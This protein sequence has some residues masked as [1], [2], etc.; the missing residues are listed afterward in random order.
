MQ[1]APKSPFRVPFDGGFDLS[2][3]ATAPKGS[4]PSKK[5]CKK[6]L[7]AEVGRIGKLQRALYAEDK[8]ALLLVFQ[9]MDAAGKDSTI[10]A[11]TTGVN[12]AGFQVSSFKSPSSLEL[13]H[14]WLWR[15]TSHLPQRGRIGVFNR[16]YYEEVLVVRAQPKLLKYQRLPRVPDGKALWRERYASI[17]DHELHL[18]RNGTAVVKFFLHV[19]KDEQ[20]RRFISRIDEVEKNWKFSLGDLGVRAQWK[21]YQ[22]AYGHALNATSRPWAPWYCIPADDKP[23]MRATVAKIVADTLASMAPRYPELA[24]EERA[25][26]ASAR[27]DLVAE[28]GD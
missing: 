25:G 1:F 7:E 20:A 6:A 23:Y 27:A 4:R 18:A 15:T 21:Q 26:L 10:R 11:V 14:D 24:E 12:P 13:D 9:A 5:Q 22:S 17:V 3:A 8:Q 2:G 19:S 28:M 16:S